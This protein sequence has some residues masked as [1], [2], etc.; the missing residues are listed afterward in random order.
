MWK[1]ILMIDVAL[2]VIF[3]ISGCELPQGTGNATATTVTA[4]SP[5]FGTATNATTDTTNDNPTPWNE[6]PGMDGSLC[7]APG[8]IS[9]SDLSKT[10]NT[11]DGDGP[12]TTG[13]IAFLCG[14]DQ[15]YVFIADTCCLYPI[16]NVQTNQGSITATISGNAVAGAP[17]N[18]NGEPN[19]EQFTSVY[20]PDYSPNQ[21]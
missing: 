9:D 12:N 14:P 3:L 4:T 21:N 18:C 2:V 16:D 10:L 5:I 13:P 8:A 11:P 19:K 17:N 20:C 15:Q 6:I 1:Q 7:P